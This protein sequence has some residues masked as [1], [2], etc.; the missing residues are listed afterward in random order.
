MSNYTHI[1]LDFDE[2]IYNHHAYVEWLSGYLENIGLSPRKDLKESFDQYHVKIA[3]NLR[4]YNHRKHL[5]DVLNQEWEYF[6]AEI[7]KEISNQNV[8][9]CY[10]DSHEALMRL[11][12]EKK[13]FRI[14]TFGNS[15][16][17]YFKIRTCQVINYLK[18]P[19]HIVHEPKG[20]FIRKH[21]GDRRIKGILVDDKYPIDVPNNWIH[22][23]VNRQ[24]DNQ[25]LKDNQVEFK[26]R[27]LKDVVEDIL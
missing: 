17:Q 3:P 9:F 22:Y 24:V 13:D 4:L 5:K 10:D 11:H 21:F 23:W 26:G 2:T 7:E 16:Y 6:S 15:E 18:I 27:S 20:D 25:D 19:V 1:F 14:L 8:D 12:E